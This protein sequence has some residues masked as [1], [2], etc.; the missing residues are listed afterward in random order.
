MMANITSQPREVAQ[1]K[2]PKVDQPEDE[3]EGLSN[4]DA[5]E[6]TSLTDF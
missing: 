6:Q 4:Q 1:E 5:N 2:T 3:E